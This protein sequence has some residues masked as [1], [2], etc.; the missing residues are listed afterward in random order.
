MRELGMV[1]ISLRRGGQAALQRY[2]LPDPARPN[3][4]T[5][6][7][8]EKCEFIESV[9]IATCN[10]VEVF[11][12]APR[13]LSVADARQRL[14]AYFQLSAEPPQLAQS[15]ATELHAYGGEGAVEHLF[16]VAA[17]LDSVMIGE[18]QI[19]G[20]VKSAQR[21]AVQAG[22]AGALLAPVFEASYEAAKR[23][24]HQTQV[25]VGAVSMLS[26]ARQLIE[27]RLQ[28]GQGHLAVVGAGP[29]AEQCGRLFASLP[30]LAL[31][32]VNRTQAGAA[33]LAAVHGGVA[34]DLVDFLAR[35]GPFDVLVSATAAPP[36][37]LGAAFFAQL[38]GPPPLLVDLAVQRDV[39][40]VAAAAAGATL[41]DL[42]ALKSLADVSRADRERALLAAR[43]LLEEALASFC[44]RWTERAVVPLVRAVRA[45]V[46]ATMQA[47]LQQLLADPELRLDDAGVARM[48]RWA[49]TL[50]N[51][52][53]HPPT[54]GLKRLAQAHG[55]E[56]VATYLNLE[57]A[58]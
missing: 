17:S 27:A 16:A 49:Q 55:L 37:L 32:F 41:Y 52:L 44:R 26:L 45:E 22:L 18:A 8:H 50:A 29:L 28:S 46:H 57:S 34:R 40:P 31:T 25:G 33:S 7:L 47:S 9:Y 53:A 36:H 13:H 42:D 56:A 24:R 5:R 23:V 21:D 14:Y 43:L 19:L 30:G 12:V 38:S 58:S 51:K 48:Q 11:F 20:Q 2:T 35:P 54:L 3:L 10:R 15:A 39:D 1:G 6:D 4:S